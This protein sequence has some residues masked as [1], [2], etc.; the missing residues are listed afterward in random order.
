MGCEFAQRAEWNADKSLDWHLLEYGPHQGVQRL[1]R[2]LNNVYRHFP[3]LHQLDC[4]GAGFE[5]IVHDDVDHSV[6]AF[7]RK[8]RDGAFAIAVSNFTPMPRMGYRLGV[9][10]PGRYREIINTDNG[11]YGGSGVGNDV[12]ASTDMAWHGRPQSVQVD[13]PPLATVIWVL[14]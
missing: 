2:D 12:V 13:V 4:D 5:W 1:V 10:E 14:D 6:F 3:A 9:P 8:A 7:I 11:I